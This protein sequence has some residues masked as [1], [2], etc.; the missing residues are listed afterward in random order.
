MSQQTYTYKSLIEAYIETQKKQPHPD[1]DRYYDARLDALERAFDLPLS[2][3]RMFADGAPPRAQGL[4]IIFADAV[5][6]YVSIRTPWD[7]FLESGAVLHRL[8]G[9]GQH[10]QKMFEYAYRISGIARE[11]QAVHLE[12]IELLF[13]MM[14]GEV[15]TV[16]TS[17]DLLELGFDDTTEPRLVDY[18]DII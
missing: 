6:S 8:Q 4:W 9:W 10:K 15:D 18:P 1:F 11:N 13:H 17:D 16:V 12:M 14:H 7:T 2:E 5:A 3:K